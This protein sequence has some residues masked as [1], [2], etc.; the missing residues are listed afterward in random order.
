MN[1][2]LTCI[3]LVV[4]LS[5]C[6][7]GYVPVEAFDKATIMCSQNGGLYSVARYTNVLQFYVRCKNSAVFENVEIK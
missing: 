2:I 6:V 7:D 3:I 5:G 4:A 1:K